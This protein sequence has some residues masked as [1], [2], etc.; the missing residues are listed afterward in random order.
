MTNSAARESSASTISPTTSTLAQ[1]RRRSPPLPP[2]VPSLRTIQYGLAMA[3][4]ATVECGRCFEAMLPAPLKVVRAE[5]HAVAPD[6]CTHLG[7]AVASGRDYDDAL[8]RGAP[9][10]AIVSASLAG[11]HFELGQPLGR[12]LRVGESAWLTVVGVVSDRSDARSH[13]DYAI[14]V[15]LAQAAPENIEILVD[16]PASSLERALAAAPAGVAVD[17]VRSAAEVFSSQVWFQNL[18]RALAWITMGL[19]GVGLWTSATN[20]AGAARYEVAVR[21]AVGATRR[22][23][24]GFYVGFAGRRLA[25]ALTLGGVALALSR[26]GARDRLSRDPAG[27]LVGVGR[28]RGMD[29]GALRPG[30][31]RAGGARDARAY[32]A[33]ARRLTPT[34]RS[35]V[36]LSEPAS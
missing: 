6:T 17:P 14:Y 21:R 32:R 8:D 25:L 9:S 18:L 10:V 33:G 19:V 27:G 5:V 7:V 15:P 4:E 36:A 29:L 3:G 31:G 23:S 34:T 16:G 11:R 26:R 12:R 20:E 28:G 13:Q 30:L 1:R 22:S 2:R 35:S 24:V